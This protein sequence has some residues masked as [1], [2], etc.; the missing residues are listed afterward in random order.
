MKTLKVCR[1]LSALLF[2]FF[3]SYIGYIAYT[4][5][6]NNNLIPTQLTPKGLGSASD[7]FI[8]RL[9][10][11]VNPEFASQVQNSE[12]WEQMLAHLKYNE[13]VIQSQKQDWDVLTCLL[14]FIF[15]SP[16]LSFLICSILI[17]RHKETI[18]VL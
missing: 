3:V 14:R 16:L 13:A 18:S 15:F 9:G 10:N 2:L 4:D 8:S 7:N 12:S 17:R 1:S 6:P 5:E 11:E